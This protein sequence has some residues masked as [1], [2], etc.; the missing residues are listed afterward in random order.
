MVSQA[1]IIS[2][3]HKLVHKEQVS[4][5]GITSVSTRS[6]LEDSIHADLEEHRSEC[7]VGGAQQQT[8]QL[9]GLDLLYIYII[10][11]YIHI[12]IYIVLFLVFVFV[13]QRDGPVP[14]N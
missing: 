5:G 3:Y 9:S 14:S 8:E 12:Y 6:S 13:T 11:V 10:C 4:Q 1:G 7:D 2:W